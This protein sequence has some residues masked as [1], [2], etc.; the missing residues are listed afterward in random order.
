MIAGL[1]DLTVMRQTIQHCGIHFLV[2]KDLISLAE[3]S[4]WWS[5]PPTLAHSAWR[6]DETE[7]VRRFGQTEDSPT[8]RAPRIGPR[9]E[10]IGQTTAFAV[11]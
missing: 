7:A 1:D 3:A 10:L 5:P 2:L 4:D 6:S 9:A 11:A 8:R